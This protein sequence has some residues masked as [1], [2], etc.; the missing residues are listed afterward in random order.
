MDID[1][2]CIAESLVDQ[3]SETGLDSITR[4]NLEAHSVA[5]NRLVVHGLILEGQGH[6]ARKRLVKLIERKIEKA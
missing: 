2:G 1:L 5:I 3:L 6:D 4:L